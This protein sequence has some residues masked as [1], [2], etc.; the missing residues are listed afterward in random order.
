MK[1]N[2]EL[3]GPPTIPCSSSGWCHVLPH[4]EVVFLVAEAIPSD[5][6]HLILRLDISKALIHSDNVIC[7][8][9][10]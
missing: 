2:S 7:D 5:E 6:S 3:V 1:V 10:L 8:H 4:V 9:T